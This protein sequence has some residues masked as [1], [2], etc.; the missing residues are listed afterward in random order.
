MKV[1]AQPDSY[2]D[3]LE[4]IF[5]T[6]LV[7]GVGCTLLVASASPEAKALLDSV[8]TEADLGL[9]KGIKAL[10]VL[11]PLGIALVSRTV[12][13]HDKISDLFRI[14]RY[15]DTRHILFRMASS[16]GLALD[17][18]TRKRICSI[19]EPL[20][21][22]VFYRYA[23]FADPKIDKQL[24]RTAL[25]HWGWF[26]VGV[27][28]GILFAIT[29]IILL[30]LQAQTQLHICLLLLLLSGILLLVQWPPCRESAARE[31]EAILDDPERKAGISGAL[32]EAIAQ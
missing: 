6:T 31:V 25:D 18:S 22:R 30:A 26:W 23:G 12:L 2:S 28:A 3:M 4:R 16:V 13:L 9:V 8:K 27:E 7:A 32:A 14:R 21:Y 10:Y 20:M 15:F 19:R 5:V 17:P 11:I 24:I 29:S 1:I